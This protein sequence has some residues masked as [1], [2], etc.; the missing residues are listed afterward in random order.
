MLILLS[1]IVEALI[2]PEQSPAIVAG[3]DSDRLTEAL[4]RAALAQ[5]PD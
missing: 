2:Y 3:L 4:T 5:L 1:T